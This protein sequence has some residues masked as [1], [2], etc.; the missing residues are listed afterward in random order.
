MLSKTEALYIYYDLFF[1][2]TIGI[3]F[4]M[5]TINKDRTCIYE[6]AITGFF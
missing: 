5:R 3:D 1:F 2:I 4:Y 6:A